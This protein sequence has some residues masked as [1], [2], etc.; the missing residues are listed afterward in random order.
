MSKKEQVTQK[1][2]PTQRKNRNKQRIYE[3][4]PKAVFRYEQK[5]E[6]TKTPFHIYEGKNP[7]PFFKYKLE[8]EAAGKTDNLNQAKQ[9]TAKAA[10]EK[11]KAEAAKKIADQDSD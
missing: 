2:N 1:R 6:D 7:A 9:G 3:M 4:K 8:G 5:E 10:F 11:A